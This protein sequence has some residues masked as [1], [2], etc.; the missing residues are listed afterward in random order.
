MSIPGS[1]GDGRCYSWRYPLT[2]QGGW[3]FLSFVGIGH[4]FGRALR[5]R[6]LAGDG[7]QSHET[8]P[9]ARKYPVH[10]R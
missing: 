6:P 5:G 4:G 8:A 3:G 2:F 9:P 1:P 10:P 7:E